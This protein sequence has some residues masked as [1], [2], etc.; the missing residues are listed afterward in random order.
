MNVVTRA[1]MVKKISEEAGITHKA[2]NTTISLIYDLM[3]DTVA[4]QKAFVI[5]GVGTIYGFLRPQKMGR[6]PRNG[7]VIVCK[8]KMQ[9][10]MKS[11]FKK[12]EGK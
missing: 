4:E 1:E 12:K 9:A 11:Y 10:K 5:P 8:E 6:D 2:A 3:R 7:N